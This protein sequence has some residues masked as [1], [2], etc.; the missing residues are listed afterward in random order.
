M[1]QI[2]G[3]CEAAHRPALALVRALFQSRQAVSAPFCRWSGRDQPTTVFA[4]DLS[5]RQRS[6]GAANDDRVLGCRAIRGQR[7]SCRCR[8]LVVPRRRIRDRIWGEVFA[9]EMRCLPY[10]FC[11]WRAAIPSTSSL[12]P[13]A[14]RW[15]ESS[16]SADCPS[17]RSA[18]A[19]SHCNLDCSSTV[20]PST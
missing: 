4:G 10:K 16:V 7:G 19:A 13:N 2:S 1:T 17:G 20:N 14:N 11:G 6:D 8:R 18:P 15:P 9:E 3:H 5:T 12:S